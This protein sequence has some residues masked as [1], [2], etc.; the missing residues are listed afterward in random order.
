ML[1]CL[2]GLQARAALPSRAGAV[3]KPIQVSALLIL[4]AFPREFNAQG[5]GLP[6]G[7]LLGLLAGSL[8]SAAPGISGAGVCACLL[9]GSQGVQ[10]AVCGSRAGLGQMC[11]GQDCW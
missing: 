3:V 4:R 7:L 10:P 2:W 6:A 5:L 11:L 9:P 8:G 1:P